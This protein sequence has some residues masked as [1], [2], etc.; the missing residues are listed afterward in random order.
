MITASKNEK[1]KLCV[2]IALHI[3]I[4]LSIKCTVAAVV[5]CTVVAQI[6]YEHI[7]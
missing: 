1:D 2:R 5:M 6:Y 7:I 4:T 3:N